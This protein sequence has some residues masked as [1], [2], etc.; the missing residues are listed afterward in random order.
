MTN[1]ESH[2]LLC[3]VRLDRHVRSPTCCCDFA[4]GANVRIHGR[5][6]IVAPGRIALVLVG[7]K[8]LCRDAKQ[9]LHIRSSE[10]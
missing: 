3:H 9:R 5:V 2:L 10:W 1:D 4:V 6:D 8:I 7:C